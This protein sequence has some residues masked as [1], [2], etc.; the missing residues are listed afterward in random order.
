MSHRVLTDPTWE[1]N[2]RCTRWTSKRTPE[3]KKVVSARYRLRLGYHLSSY[4]LQML[5]AKANKRNSSYPTS[6]SPP[7]YIVDA[8]FR[9]LHQLHGSHRYS[10]PTLPCEV[11]GAMN[12]KMTNHDY[13]E[14]RQQYES[15]AAMQTECETRTRHLNVN[16][17]KKEMEESYER[18]GAQSGWMLDCWPIC[19][20]LL[21]V[22]R[23]N[24]GGLRLESLLISYLFRYNWQR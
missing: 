15:L 24:V 19:I 7:G 1:Q 14:G 16:L 13:V 22:A 12:A 10:A 21:P 3:R 2:L 20:A 6:T 18:Y 17:K 11:R 23:C 5:L 9:C 4:A 8:F